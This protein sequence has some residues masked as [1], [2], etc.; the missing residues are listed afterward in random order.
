MADT[1]TSVP[2]S[3]PSSSFLTEQEISELLLA[4]EK[5]A[6]AYRPETPFFRLPLQVDPEAEIV[7]FFETHCVPSGRQTLY[8][9][10]WQGSVRHHTR[11]KVD[12]GPAS[13]G[14]CKKAR[15]SRAEVPQST[16]DK[17]GDFMT[18]DRFYLSGYRWKKAKR[19]SWRKLHLGLDLVSGETIC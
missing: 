3:G 2:I 11:Y 1:K 19:K 15:I 7:E 13:A 16:A 18:Q 6:K 8:V 12:F 14:G 10:W 17:Y 5:T 4:G 9:D